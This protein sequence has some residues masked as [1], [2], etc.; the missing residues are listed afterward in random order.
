MIACL[1]GAACARASITLPESTPVMKME[2]VFMKCMSTPWK[3]FDL[4][5]VPGCDLIEEFHKRSYHAI[6]ASLNSSTM[7]V[8]AAKPYS[9]PCWKSSLLLAPS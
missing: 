9:T 4:C 3:A 2:T 1:N 8:A 5:F 7:F 6:W